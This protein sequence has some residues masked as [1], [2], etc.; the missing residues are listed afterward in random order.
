MVTKELLLGL[1]RLSVRDQAATT[2]SSLCPIKSLRPSK[3]IQTL[4]LGGGEALSLPA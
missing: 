2:G 1:L 3:T 4:P